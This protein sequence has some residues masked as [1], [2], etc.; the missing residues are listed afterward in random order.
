MGTREIK[1]WPEILLLYRQNLDNRE[2]QTDSTAA[3]KFYFT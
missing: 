2:G 3:D 1:N